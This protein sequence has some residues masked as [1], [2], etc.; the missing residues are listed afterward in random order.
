MKNH[1]TTLA[2]I[3]ISALSAGTHAADSKSM[4]IESW[5]F[6]CSNPSLTTQ[7]GSSPEARAG[8]DL[9]AAK[10]ARAAASPSSTCTSPDGAPASQAVRES[11]SKASLGRSKELTGHIT[12]VK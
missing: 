5:S 9:K 1:L 7:P 12:L 10:G 3:A 2:F 8:Y 4:S 11:P 6:G